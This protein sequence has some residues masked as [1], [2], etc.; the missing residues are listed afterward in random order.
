MDLEEVFKALESALHFQVAIAARRRLF[1]RA[2]VVG[3][4]GRAILIL[5]RISSGK[6]ALVEA[7][8]RAGASYYSDQYAVL[9]RFGRVHAYARPLSARGENEPRANK[10]LEAVGSIT[11]RRPSTARHGASRQGGVPACSRRRSEDVVLESGQL[12]DPPDLWR[13][14]R[15]AVDAAQSVTNL[16]NGGIQR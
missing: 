15:L 12:R 6:T 10:V 2:G 11:A 14:G 13:P 16:S 7:L 9:D 8:V 5:S 1:I 4:Q 3:C